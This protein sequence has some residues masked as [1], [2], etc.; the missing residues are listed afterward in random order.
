MWDIISGDF[1]KEISKEKC[2]DNVVKNIQPGSI[3]VFHDSAKASHNMLF[4]LPESL[5]MLR[6][7]GYT[8]KA[9]GEV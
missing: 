2:L 5:R 3:I 7:N 4:A 9:I 8:F 6:E 1:D